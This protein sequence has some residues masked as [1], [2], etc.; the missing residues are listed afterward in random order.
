MRVEHGLV[1]TRLDILINP[2]I[3]VPE[4]I[5]RIT[6]ITNEMLRGKP[7]LDDVLDEILE[8]LGDDF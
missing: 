2:G 8:F 1:T 7:K 6:K 5:T 4:H 3:V